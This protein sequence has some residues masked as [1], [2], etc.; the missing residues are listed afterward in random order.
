MLI[1]V[2]QEN[3]RVRLDMTCTLHVL[4]RAA[5]RKAWTWQNEEVAKERNS[6]S[7]LAPSWARTVHDDGSISESCPVG[8][9]C[10]AESSAPEP[11]ED[12]YVN[13]VGEA[14]QRLERAFKE[15]SD[16]IEELRYELEDENL[17][18]ELES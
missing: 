4:K 5:S 17:G 6:N 18:E 9:G 16:A 11:T 13:A 15:I 3:E 1:R 10:A 8:C 2:A 14:T 7:T 12:E